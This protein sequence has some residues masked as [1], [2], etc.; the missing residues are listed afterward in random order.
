MRR[1]AKH[2]EVVFVEFVQSS[3]KIA[4]QLKKYWMK[5]YSE[6]KI[7]ILLQSYD[8]TFWTRFHSLMRCCHE[9]LGQMWRWPAEL[10][11]WYKLDCI[12]AREWISDLCSDLWLNFKPKVLPKSFK[13]C[14]DVVRYWTVVT[15]CGVEICKIV[16]FEIIAIK[17]LHQACNGAQWEF[18]WHGDS[19]SKIGFSPHW[20]FFRW[21]ESV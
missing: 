11:T 6:D 21:N 8:A 9:Y 14:N 2:Q 3:Q 20:P 7:N 12:I 10:C 4:V 16:F 5:F 13:L 15:P 17:W 1:V 18:I 19:I